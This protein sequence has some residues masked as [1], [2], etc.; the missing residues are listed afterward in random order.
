MDTLK[1]LMEER[2]IKRGNE[3]PRKYGSAASSE[4]LFDSRSVSLEPEAQRIIA[5]A[6]WE[7]LEPLLPAQIG[8]METAAIPLVAALVAKSREM[9]KPVNG[10][11]IR[12]S[13]KKS[14][15]VKF[16]E[17]TL[18]DTPIVL[19]DDLMNSGGSILHQVEILKEEGRTVRAVIVLVRF[20]EE[21]YYQALHDAGVRIIALFTLDDFGLKMNE[22]PKP[23]L[24]QG[25]RVRWR[26]AAPNP[27]FFYVVPKSAPA[28]DDT[29]VYFGSDSGWF[30][31]IRK[32]DGSEA[33]K[34]KVGIHAKGK[35]IFSCPL[36]YQGTVFF[37]A[38]D[39]NV[40]ALDTT[41]GKRKWVCMEADW[42]GSSPDIAP[43]LNVLF[44]GL[45]FGLWRKR[46][47]I[48]AIDIHTG[49]K[50]WE[51]MMPNYTHASPLFI[52]KHQQVAIGS[53]DGAVYLFDARTGTLLWKH[54]TGALAEKDLD[55]GFS[56]FDIKGRC[57]Y[58][59]K[60]DIVIATNIHGDVV[61]IH[62]KTG[63]RFASFK[64]DFG[65]YSDPVIHADSLLV[66]NVNKLLY[67]INLD[68]FNIQWQWHADARIFA[69]PIVVEGRIFIGSNT[70]RFVELSMNDGKE[71]GRI[72]LAERIV[73]KTAYDPKEK[74]FFVP[75]LAN[76][77]FCLER[78][79]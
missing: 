38:Y 60:R 78:V 61:A 17:G 36:V 77:I 11:Y 5:D 49:K 44:V 30:W 29:H 40:Y 37:G 4:W 64:A 52:R 15:L 76:E 28:I 46:G 24:T 26:C 63:E 42:V 16:I 59:P 56:P 3:I 45:E 21:S 68:T 41:S 43:E 22:S 65:F 18:N 9:G 69:T 10:F 48:A 57:A 35:S 71:S 34:Y 50:I 27:N 75:T 47:G 55:T 14:G 20:R 25:F 2:I 51:Y 74:L 23:A 54:E 7:R 33:W 32:K 39:G 79:I 72:Q 19:I 66:A 1:Q 70:G 31:A 12:K 8:G 62:R 58:D 13:R 67:S 53:N 73:N 6:L